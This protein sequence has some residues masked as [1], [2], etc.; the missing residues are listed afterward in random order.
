MSN[1][2]EYAESL[3]ASGLSI[4]P[5]RPDG[6]K[7]PAISSWKPYQE[8]K[9]TSAEL[10]QWY[11][12]G[13]NNGVA[14][15]CGE[16]SGSLEVMDFDDADTFKPWAEAVKQE[17]GGSELLK[18]LVIVKS[19][20]GWHV[21]YRCPGHIQGN[22]KLAQR[23]DGDGKVHVLIETRGSGGYVLA[24]GSPAACHPS[25]KLYVERQ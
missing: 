8:Q 17:V 10:E 23:Q 12:N 7:A 2:L 1:S 4:I 9:A 14:V 18:K 25:G 24:P 13:F 16:V 11:G 15:L 22:Q 6:S 3:V 19:P 20:R 21:Y 5:I